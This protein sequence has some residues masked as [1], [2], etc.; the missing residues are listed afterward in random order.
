[1]STPD[2]GC[3]SHL[4]D[5]RFRLS[6][7]RLVEI[8]FPSNTVRRT[9]IRIK[10]KRRGAKGHGVRKQKRLL[11]FGGQAREQ[12]PLVIKSTHTDA[13]EDIV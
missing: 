3:A 13:Q 4:T 2:G 7:S 11:I 12:E 9:F 5:R 8:I 1:M 6:G 10:Q